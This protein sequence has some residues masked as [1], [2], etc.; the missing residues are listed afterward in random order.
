MSLSYI[1]E[2]WFPNREHSKIFQ[3]TF[4]LCLNATHSFI[5]FVSLRNTF[6]HF[7]TKMKECEYLKEKILFYAIK[8]ETIEPN[9]IKFKQQTCLSKA[10]LPCIMRLPACCVCGNGT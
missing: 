4:V 2:I 3:A 7:L 9:K 10:A 1:H 8:I 5:C 6:L